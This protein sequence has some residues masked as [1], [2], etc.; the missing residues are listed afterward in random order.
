MLVYDTHQLRIWVDKNVHYCSHRPWGDEVA[1]VDN[2]DTVVVI[3]YD[4][5]LPDQE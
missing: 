5:L 2:L 4:Y 1:V 3:D